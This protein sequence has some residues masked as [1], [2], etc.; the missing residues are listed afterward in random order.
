M[1]DHGRPRGRHRRR[2][3][4]VSRE[5][6]VAAGLRVAD[7]DG[8]DALS[9]RRVAQELG[10]GTMTLYSHVANK[11]ELLDLMQDEVMDEMLVP[12]V[13]ADWREAMTEI[14]TRTT[15]ALIRHAWIAA[16]M[17]RRPL[18]GPRALM[19]VEQSLAALEP[20][21]LETR[22]A[23]DVLAIV[24]DYAIGYALRIIT[25][26]HWVPEGAPP[27]RMVQDLPAELRSL[28]EAG[29][30][31]RLWRAAVSGEFSPP[32]EE[33]FATGLRWLLDG[34]AAGLAAGPPRP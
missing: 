2:P 33:R 30:Y 19:H 18:P 14:A 12:E 32:S 8:L 16:D 3:P 34:I 24:D 17:S 25:S 22:V 7:A 27:G 26:R 20:L 21:G 28:L 6:I 10:V 23:G 9:M 13:P 1:N 4:A 31:P 5:E 29:D 11:H 15:R